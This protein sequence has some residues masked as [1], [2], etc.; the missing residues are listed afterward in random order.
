MT[1]TQSIQPKFTFVRNRYFLPLDLLLLSALPFASLYLRVDTDAWSGQY[2]RALLLFS[3]L[4]LVVKLPAFYAMGLYRRYW[5]YASVDDLTSIVLAVGITSAFIALVFLSAQAI[6]VIPPTEL[7]RSVPF[8][9]GVLTLLAVGGTRFS[10]RAAAS[11]R[12]ARD[13]NDQSESKRVLVVGAGDAGAMI[14]REMQNN[15]RVQL[16]PVGFVDDD[17]KKHGMSILG[18]PVL[19]NRKDIPALVTAYGIREVIIAMPTASGKVIREIV[20]LCEIARVSSRTMPGIYEILSGRVG[21]SELRNVDIEDLLRRDP[22]MIDSEEVVRMLAGTR[23]LVTGAGGSIGSELCRQIARCGPARLTLLGHGENSLFTIE[24]ELRRKWPS[25]CLDVI[26]ADIRDLPRLRMLFERTHPQVLFHAAAHK[27]VPLMESNSEDAITNN[28]VGTRVLVGLAE[29]Y[30][31]ERFVLIS[32]DKAVNPINVMGATKRVAE[33]II[34][35]AA[36][37][38]GRPYVSVRF[39]NVLGSRGS[40]VPTF[41]QQ[42]AQ[43]G[44]VTVTHPDMSRYFMT[45]PEAVQLVLQAAALGT[46]EGRGE[47]FV[48]DMGDPIKIVDLARDLI[49]LSGFEVGRDIEIVF[50]G[51]RPGERLYEELFVPG[52]EYRR[53]RHEKIFVACEPG[54]PA[55]PAM[56][57]GGKLDALVV[58]LIQAAESGRPDELRRLLK[59]ILPNYSPAELISAEN[60]EAPGSV[61]VTAARSDSRD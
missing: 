50:T 43:G 53:T 10:V 39:G 27:H 20:A 44:P 21:V 49:E 17:W 32:T 24:H 18:V 45:I 2:T 9:D 40:V 13:R 3:V 11:A 59:C 52:E 31:V 19:G 29:R 25:L 7:P 16:E 57:G 47:V 23:V 37:R 33:M 14:V 42:I 54:M 46:R 30:G 35:D 15:A 38:T 56:N 6:N 5:R 51:L 26:V 58:E 55:T 41:R 61:A 1:E 4:A 60:L 8:I 28:V 22:V 34:Q 12:R 36:R 48:L